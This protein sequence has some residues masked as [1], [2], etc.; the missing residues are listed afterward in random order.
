M[1]RIAA[2]RSGVEQK[3]LSSK[4][5][6]PFVDRYGQ[7][8]HDDWPGK[9]HSDG[10]LAA[11]RAA[12]DVWLKDHATSPIPDVDKY[13]GWAGGPQLKATGFFRTE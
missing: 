10:E 7:F 4:T 1:R 11:A 3:M 13:G 12:E 6:L 2:S 9:I 8:M 5:F